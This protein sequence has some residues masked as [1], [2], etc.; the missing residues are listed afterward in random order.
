[1]A[2]VE[3]VLGL[4]VLA[5]LVAGVAER[6]RAPAPSLLVLAG[7]VVALLPG[8]PEVRLT[9]EVVSLVV[10]PPLLF[11]SAAELPARDLRAVAGPVA[12]LALGLVAVTAVAVAVVV[13]AV[14]PQVPLAAAFVLGAVLASTD[15]VA[16]TALSRQLSL[17][18]RV[19]T[20]VQAESLLNDATSLV[21]F[22]V[23]VGV[24]VSGG[25]LDLGRAGL[26]F[27]AL[28]AGGALVGILVAALA[29]LARA[30][31]GDSLV[32]TSVALV[33]PYAC[34][35]A[36]ESV[37]VSGVTAVVVAGVGL[38]GRAGSMTSGATRLQVTAVYAAVVFLLE[39]VVF[40]LIGLQ[41]PG[42]VQRVGSSDF[43][44]PA[45]VVTLVTV[46]TRVA[47]V[48]PLAHVPRLLG[49]PGEAPGWRALAVV[50]WA[51]TRGVVPLAAA[52][53]V[54]LS[55]RGGAPFPAREL[56]LVLATSVIVLT[57]V[58]Q[59]LTLAPLVRRL[60]VVADAAAEEQ[61]EALARHRTAQAALARLEELLDLEAVPEHV[62]GRL[63]G[64]LIERV[65]RTRVRLEEPDR[66]GA[67]TGAAFARLRRELLQTETAELSRLRAAGLI[68]EGVRRAVQ[69]QLDLE[70]TALD[71]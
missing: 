30:R 58:G 60:G 38:A 61:E 71:R 29:G 40:A 67:S 69:R 10:L 54:P 25:G 23:S 65:D 62:A 37:H 15:P 3:V 9:P 4:V 33:T 47:W 53:S 16:I 44:L 50:S 6:L 56:L 48:W 12:A 36:A 26:Q 24:V 49:R 66:R 19:A 1:M 43:V 46:L 13:H 17:P 63:R 21:L 57:L 68:G 59:G 51:G 2:A 27:V 70:D 52:L 7:L 31:T 39:S 41:L 55:V 64:G 22:T 32:E 34:F 45:V 11:A 8:V 5:T 20:V 35:V 42:L 14:L 18:R 28:G